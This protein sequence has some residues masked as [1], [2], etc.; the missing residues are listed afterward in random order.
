MVTIVVLNMAFNGLTE[1]GV[2]DD[3]IINDN[4]Q[5]ITHNGALC[6]HNN[7][8][9]SYYEIATEDNKYINPQT[10]TNDSFKLY[11][12]DT[13]QWEHYEDLADF[14]NTYGS[15]SSN[16]VTKNLL[17]TNIFWGILAVALGVGIAVGVTVFGTGISDFAQ[18]LVFTLSLW[19]AV[20]LFL[21]STSYDLLM[22]PEIS[23]MGSFIYLGLTL[24]FIIGVGMTI[25][26]EG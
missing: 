10:S 3:I 7:N 18:T 25:S 1:P 23:P 4:G 24:T 20:W 26:D 17:D 19:G 16:A 13:G 12:D 8:T 22:S 11:N 14:E 21:T 5:F 15:S 6:W 2:G 9:G